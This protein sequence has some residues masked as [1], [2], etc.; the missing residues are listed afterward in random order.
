MLLKVSSANM[1][2]FSDIEPVS[3]NEAHPQLC[4]ILYDEEYK[5]TMGTLLALLQ[6]REFSLRALHLSEIGIG[7]LASHYT[8]WVYRYQILCHL[9]VDLRQELDWCEQV[10]L[11]NEKN[12]QIWNYRQLIIEK[13]LRDE[14]EDHAEE[15]YK[16]ELPII[17]CMLDSDCKN[18]HVW[19]YRKWLV[20][21]FKK[22]SDPRELSFVN[23]L[24]KADLYNN[25]A[26]LH[27][28]FLLFG[29][30]ADIQLPLVESEIAFTQAAIL[31]SPHNELSWNYLRGVFGQCSVD[32][33]EL[34]E[35]CLGLGTC[36]FAIE[37]L[38]EMYEE[39]GQC[40]EAREQLQQLQVH[41]RIR[42]NYWKW[43]Y[44][45]ITA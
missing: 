3:L 8:L 5:S 12:Y 27:R 24:L 16:R 13:L 26:W 11:E 22:Q 38:A 7:L 2:D 39:A 1:Y 10:A 4:Q 28:F 18:H 32:K 29:E 43:R 44:E 33:A 19:L 34:R 25:S 40:I 14:G 41:D 45:Q 42:V 9:E 21:R 15:C 37:M 35:F 23:S 17:Q 30:Q 6:K 20:A 36:T 31:A